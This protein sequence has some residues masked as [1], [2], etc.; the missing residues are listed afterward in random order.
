[1]N[2]VDVATALRAEAK[3]TNERRL[4]VLSGERDACYDAVSVVLDGISVPIAATA[5][6]GERDFLRCRQV[7]PRR[8]GELLGT[9]TECIVVD[10]HDQLRPNTLGKV[11][12]AV[13][14]GGLLVL[15]APPLDDWPTRRDGF[16][17]GMAVPP[18]SVDD[19]TGN[20]RTR[21]VETLRAHRGIATVDVNDGTV[22]DDGLTR[23]APRLV[24][25]GSDENDS[26]DLPVPTGH[27][28]P[29][30]A[31]EACR[32]VDQVETVHDFE[33]LRESNRALVLEADRGRGKSS[34]AGIA[35][36]SFAADGEDVL[37]TAPSFANAAEAFDR[38]RDLL[39]TLDVAGDHP[40][41][42]H[43]VTTTGGAVRY[44][45]PQ[46]AAATAEEPD[47]LVVDEAAAISVR[48]LDAT[49]AAD[50]VAYASTVH[51]YEGAGRGFAVRFRDHLDESDHEVR[52]SR[53]AEPIRYAA[54]D[55]VE[56]WSFAALGLDARPAVDPLVA[57]A[58]PDTVEYG[59]PTPA[60]LL[61]DPTLLRETFGLLVLAHYRTDPDDLA[62]LL[63]APNL[64]VR[65][66]THE[67]HVVSVALL[68]RE[69]GLD[70]RTRAACYEGGRINGNM[71]PDVLTSQ[72]RDE[73]AAGPV[74]HRVVRIATHHAVR[75]G[76][77]GSHLLERIRAEFADA[78]DWLGVGYGATPELLRFW[79][80]NGYRTVHLSTTRN[81]VSGE[82]SAVMLSPCSPAGEALHDRH[83]GWF[84]RRIGGVLT[85]AL[86]DMDPDEVRA[87]LAACDATVDLDLDE[88][89]WRAVAGTAYGAGLYDVAPTPFRE[90][91][92]KHLVD[93]APGA[94]DLS[95]QHERVLVMR[96]LQARD[97]ETVADELGY[98]SSRLA[99][100]AL[101]EG[102]R[103]L[104]DAYGDEVAAEEARRHREEDGS[105][106][107]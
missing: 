13:D 50:R 103:P 76:G 61:A 22:L 27:T 97:A 25:G 38:A 87:A 69:G 20:F 36:G 12:G 81:D 72:L 56:V 58:T 41:D 10:A 84:A 79:D 39:E 54:G 35:A 102:L 68:A 8:A 106:Q 21:F 5:L 15:L 24:R 94:P 4:L 49:L 45:P 95:P 23:P 3:A 75:S 86:R 80:R 57:D 60:D 9:T 73:A 33:F 90:L 105:N 83:A 62:R 48:L 96:V 16:D 47:V 51:G 107:G 44:E 67:G 18:F 53:L 34:A 104:V 43:L 28:F 11:V 52:E 70:A 89:D 59:R 93:P 91:A 82:Y 32:T 98:H 42:T 14:G 78:V 85:D 100:R 2:P 40:N 92:V 29:R 55:P 101:G 71:I 74:G 99:M 65:T 1:M 88:R 37:V 7:T 6:V 64:R 63:D 17:A 31:Y 30:A 19:V 46:V 77:L 26:D 66:L